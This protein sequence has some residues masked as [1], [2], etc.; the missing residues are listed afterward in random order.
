MNNTQPMLRCSALAALLFAS[1]T[2]FAAG[3]SLEEQNAVQ[4]GDFGSGGAA[5]AEDAS[6]AW[7]NPAG[8]IRIDKPQV[9]L[10]GNEIW[11]NTQFNG[12]IIQTPTPYASTTAA[13][14]NVSGGTA[15]FIPAFHASYPI[16]QNLVAGFSVTTPFGLSTDYGAST[17]VR[18][19]T[20]ET[21]LKTIDLSPSLGVKINPDF[22]V[23]LGFDE[24]RLLAT[25]ESYGG[26]PSLSPSYDTSSRNV[27]SD[28]RS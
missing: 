13:V 19:A 2:S 23:G 21:K 28:A 1:S 22:S 6:T 24:Q 11:F 10:A 27:A 3:F 15:N 26:I 9:V 7:Y 17:N 8:L 4:T 20:V 5:I 12:T 14:S 16:S 18:Y 25:F